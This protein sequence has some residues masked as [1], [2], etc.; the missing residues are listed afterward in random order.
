MKRARYEIKKTR[1]LNGSYFR[2]HNRGSQ[3]AG[4]KSDCYVLGHDL[5]PQVNLLWVRGPFRIIRSKGGNR[6][7]GLGTAYFPARHYL[8]HLDEDDIITEAWEVEAGKQHRRAIAELLGMAERAILDAARA[9]GREVIS[10]TKLERMSF[11][12]HNELPEAVSILGK[13]K[14]WVGIGWVTVGDE[15]GDEVLVDLEWLQ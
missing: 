5:G 7:D 2:A 8:L 10:I 1:V 12:N 9:S 15:R 6:Y 4:P 11:T 14:E 3:A 13:R